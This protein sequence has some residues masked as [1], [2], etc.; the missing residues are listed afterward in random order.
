MVS[1]HLSRSVLVALALSAAVVTGAPVGAQCSEPAFHGGNFVC[2]PPNLTGDYSA[3]AAGDL[4][5]DLSMEVA[6][7]KGTNL[8]VFH[9]PDSESVAVHVASDANDVCFARQ[10]GVNG[11]PALL[12]ISS[13]GLERV[14]YD[15]VQNQYLVDPVPVSDHTHWQTATL[16][17]W[18]TTGVAEGWDYGA[19]GFSPVE[20]RFF[21]AIPDGNGGFEEPEA[22]A[23]FDSAVR[24]FVPLNWNGDTRREIAVLWG[25][26]VRIYDQDGALLMS[27][28]GAVSGDA[29]ARVQ[30]T[31]WSDSLA[32]VTRVAGASHLIVFN[33]GFYGPEYPTQGFQVDNLGYGQYRSIASAN[34]DAD[35][36]GSGDLALAPVNAAHIELFYAGSSPTNWFANTPTRTLDMSAEEGNVTTGSLL[37]TNLFNDWTTSEQQEVAGQPQPIPG[38]GTVV[39][40]AQTAVEGLRVQPNL[41]ER[42]IQVGTSNDFDMALYWSACANPSDQLSQWMLDVGSGWGQIAQQSV[43]IVIRRSPNTGVVPTAH[44]SANVP[45]TGALNDFAYEF[46]GAETTT[47][48]AEENTVSYFVKLRPRTTSMAWRWSILSMTSGCASFAWLREMPAAYDPPVPIAFDDTELPGHDGLCDGQYEGDDDGH[49]DCTPGMPAL[50]GSRYIPSAVPLSYM[51]GGGGGILPGN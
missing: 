37:V 7:I 9:G 23:V 4:N 19:F 14:E 30:R 46:N 21:R 15:A 25:N 38:F 49:S 16:I 43:E 36:D 51:P 50:P 29:I 18:T 12:Y 31:G 40:D 8:I 20:Q 34:L 2:S 33:Q 13:Q 11:G 22:F 28:A 44:S 45:W 27:R 5:G 48:H 26:G 42:H 1:A 32:W 41:V 6:V 47:S 24:D 39:T 10:G 17:R 35:E 3:I